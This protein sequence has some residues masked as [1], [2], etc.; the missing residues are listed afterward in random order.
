LGLASGPSK[1]KR[2]RIM[3]AAGELFVEHGIGVVTMQQ[4][5][6]AP[7]SRSGRCTCARPSRPS[8]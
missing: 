6:I 8:Y 4:S 3:T 5:P 7:M 2:E 1:D